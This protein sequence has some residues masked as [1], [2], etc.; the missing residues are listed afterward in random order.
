MVMKSSPWKTADW[1]SIIGRRPCGR[2]GLTLAECLLALV[3]LAL[4]VTAIAYAVSAGQMQSAEAMRQSRAT[5]LAE[6]LMDEIF[7]KSYGAPAT[8]TAPARTAFTTAGKYNVFSEAAGN[9]RDATGAL[10]PAEYQMYARRAAVSSSTQA[11]SGLGTGTAGLLI[12]V[13]ISLGGD[14][15]CTLTRFMV[16]PS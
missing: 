5:M 16:N 11:I 1:S 7:S 14:T 4:A 15:V 6:S 13:T 9:L 3:I 12:T 10:C 2:R 8:G